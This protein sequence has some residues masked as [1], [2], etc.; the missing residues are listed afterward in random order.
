[1][2]DEERRQDRT[3]VLEAVPDLDVRATQCVRSCERYH[4][5]PLR[6]DGYCRD[7]LVRASQAIKDAQNSGAQ[8]EIDR[9]IATQAEFDTALEQVRALR[10]LW[11]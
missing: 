2:W 7:D 5:R 3:T 9:W 6:M 11:R 1:V 4:M 10:P 8:G